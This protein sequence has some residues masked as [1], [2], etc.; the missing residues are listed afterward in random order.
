MV[1]TTQPMLSRCWNGTDKWLLDAM[2]LFKALEAKFRAFY[3][4]CAEKMPEQATVLPEIRHSTHG[5]QSPE[6]MIQRDG[7]SE[8]MTLDSRIQDTCQDTPPQ[9]SILKEFIQIKNRAAS[10]NISRKDA[11]RQRALTNRANEQLISRANIITRDP[12]KSTAPRDAVRVTLEQ[13]K[14]LITG[15]LRANGREPDWEPELQRMV[16][17]ASLHLNGAP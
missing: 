1:S 12:G 7:T 3:L 11:H 13:A 8:E 5:H 16:V 4:K 17:G 14:E 2:K 10:S 6:E 9:R 15:V